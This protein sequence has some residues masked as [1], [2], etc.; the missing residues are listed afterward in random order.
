MKNLITFA[1]LALFSMECLSAVPVNQAGTEKQNKYISDG[2]FVGGRDH[3]LL[4]LFNVRHSLTPKFERLVFDLG[5]K[6]KTDGVE[7]PGFFHISVQ[8]SLKRIVIDLENVAESEVNSEQVAK[9][10]KNSTTFSKVSMVS[11]S[12]HK[13]LTIELPLKKKSEVEVFELVTPG[14]PGRIVMDTRPL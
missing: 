4:T 14:K 6:G 10:F 5:D 9:L 1:V 2:V 13:N 3:G 11:D 7:R 8:Y 12:L